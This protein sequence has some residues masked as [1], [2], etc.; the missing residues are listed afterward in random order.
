MTTLSE[1]ELRVL[2]NL[3]AKRAGNLTPFINIADAQ[4]LTEHGFAARSRQGWDITREGAAYLAELDAKGP[5]QPDDDQPTPLFGR[6]P[7]KG[8]SPT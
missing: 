8:G 5:G 1:T 3:A 6:T 2:R 4:R 7:P